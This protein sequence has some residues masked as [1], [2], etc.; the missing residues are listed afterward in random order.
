MAGCVYS[1]AIV[2]LASVVLATVA[3]FLVEEPARKLGYGAADRV[4]A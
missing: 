3:H 4:V 2:V 1:G